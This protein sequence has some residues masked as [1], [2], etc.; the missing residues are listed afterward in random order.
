VI[1]VIKD[2]IW[3]LTIILP[4]ENEQ[5]QSPVYRHPTDFFPL[6]ANTFAEKLNFSVLLPYSICDAAEAWTMHMGNS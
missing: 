1:S 2:I 4:S 6:G 3:F 5:H